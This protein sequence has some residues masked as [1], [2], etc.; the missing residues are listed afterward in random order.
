MRDVRQ[1]RRTSTPVVSP[2][3]IGELILIKSIDFYIDYYIRCGTIGT[4]T[5]RYDIVFDGVWIGELWCAQIIEC[6]RY[7]VLGSVSS[8]CRRRVR[9]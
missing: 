2:R 5:K 6:Q 4:V 8:R 9:E 7:P 1:R 3:R